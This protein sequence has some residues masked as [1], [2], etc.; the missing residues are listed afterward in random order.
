MSESEEQ[1]CRKKRNWPLAMQVDDKEMMELIKKHPCLYNK[2]TAE[3]TDIPAKREIW[4]S[5]A[6]ELDVTIE[7]LRMKYR[8][9]RTRLGKHLNALRQKNEEIVLGEEFQHM[10]WL[11]PYIK[12]RDLP[13]TS[14]EISNVHSLADGCDTATKR[15]ENVISTSDIKT[16]KEV[17]V[18]VLSRNLGL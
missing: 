5:I 15:K 11:V 4:K 13:P 18:P 6:D 2:A 17:Q 7:F 8:N 1:E 9:Y 12:H 3:K 10:E 16:F 14:I